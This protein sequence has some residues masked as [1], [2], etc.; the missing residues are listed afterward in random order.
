MLDRFSYLW[1]ILW[2]IWVFLWPILAPMPFALLQFAVGIAWIASALLVIR[3]YKRR[4]I[5]FILTLPIG[6]FI[7]NMMDP[8]FTVG[9]LFAYALCGHSQAC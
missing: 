8:L 2:P 9:S 7:W 1:N 5:W 6:I 4:A 3:A